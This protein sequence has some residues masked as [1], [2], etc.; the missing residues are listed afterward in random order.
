M[1]PGARPA[2]GSVCVKEL[3][4]AM[5]AADEVGPLLDD[6]LFFCL[7]PADSDDGQYED[8]YFPH[9]DD[10][11]F[12]RL[13]CQ[14]EAHD[15]VGKPPIALRGVRAVGLRGSRLPSSFEIERWD[16]GS[17]LL[18]VL[19]RPSVA[20]NLRELT[21]ARYALTTS[22]FAGLVHALR[23]TK[24]VEVLR[25][26]DMEQEVQASCEGVLALVDVVAGMEAI[27]K[28]TL[29][30]AVQRSGKLAAM[31]DMLGAH[32][33]IAELELIVKPTLL[34]E[35]DVNALER[36]LCTNTTLSTLVL[37]QPYDTLDESD[38][39]IDDDEVADAHIG[40]M[41]GDALGAG[42]ARNSTLQKLCIC[43]GSSDALTAD[44][45]YALMDGLQRNATL[46]HLYVDAARHAPSFAD[47]VAAAVTQGSGL[48]ETHV[49]AIGG[50]TLFQ[51]LSSRSCF[52][53]LRVGQSYAYGHPRLAPGVVL[54]LAKA[55][56]DGA[57]G[58]TLEVLEL[59][60]AQETATGGFV[61]LGNALEHNQV[62]RTLRVERSP[63]DTEG[64]AALGHALAANH[65]LE[66]LLLADCQ[67]CD[68]CASALSAGL[69]R[70]QT[71]RDLQ[72]SGNRVGRSGALAV[73]RSLS[74]ASA[75][76]RLSLSSLGLGPQGLDKQLD[77]VDE[78]VAA[79]FAAAFALSG[80]LEDVD[81]GHCKVGS[82]TLDGLHKLADAVIEAA[83][84][85]YVPGRRMAVKAQLWRPAEVG[86]N[87]PTADLMRQE[88]RRLREKEY[89]VPG[90]GW[91]GD[92]RAFFK[93]PVRRVKLDV[94]E[95]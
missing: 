28:L 19:R 6:G 57:L 13:H 23:A 61:A 39:E 33:S 1:T 65:T 79:G 51:A 30:F 35:A 9:P 43:G 81:I 88:V 95:F 59:A 40:Q 5:V 14:M 37:E 31:F 15:D 50:A 36:M 21:L 64:A 47:E 92:S 67:I 66:T 85:R 4:D 49:P 18:E 45:V 38:S 80:A 11:P 75:V 60:G 42:L 2:L 89:K 29:P 34:T 70:N 87:H 32:T 82:A 71:L 17:L 91:E 55:V 86:F 7:D 90:M 62:L 52:V 44:G 22:S 72:L 20:D 83:R 3:A 46:Q 25:I 77:P 53:E 58:A 78:S 27:R 74:A 84:R 24:K 26:Q 63:V 48:R 68:E 54:E 93:N 10:E 12:V 94:L 16:I 73:A 8:A 41:L 56:A 76:R 69:A